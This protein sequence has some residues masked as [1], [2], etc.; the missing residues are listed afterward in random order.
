[1][2]DSSLVPLRKILRGR[3]LYL[4]GMMGS[5]KSS[6][7]PFLA[8]ALGYGFVDSDPVIEQLL[9][10]SIP[11]IFSEKGESYFRDI[12]SKV[13]QNIGE[14]H[15]LVVATGGGVVIRHENWGVL[16][17]GIVIWIDP[18]RNILLQR[19]NIDSSKRPLLKGENESFIDDLCRKRQPFYSEADLHIV[20]ENE[21][22]EIIAKKILDDLSRK[23]NCQGA[24]GGSQTIEP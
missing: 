5:G 18:T 14:R 2:S 9:G 21:S 4:I 22:E 6:T 3:N 13:L 11:K 15:S 10:L 19:L 17:Q 12:E 8:K 1:M 7:G 24:Q 20:V 23:I 16:H